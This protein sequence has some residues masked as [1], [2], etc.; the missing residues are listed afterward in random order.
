MKIVIG[1]MEEELNQFVIDLEAQ[2][3][4][5]SLIPEFYQPDLDLTIA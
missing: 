1:A 3:I 2:R 5:G 4:E